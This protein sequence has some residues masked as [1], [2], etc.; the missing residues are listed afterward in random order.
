[1]GVSLLLTSSVQ[2]VIRGDHQPVSVDA[3]LDVVGGLVR[4]GRAVDGELC[5]RVLRF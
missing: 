4:G 1:M 2:G 5:E 3:L